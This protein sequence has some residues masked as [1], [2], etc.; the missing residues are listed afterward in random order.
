M[1]KETP[2]AVLIDMDGV[3]ADFDLATLDYMRREIPGFKEK[4][5]REHFYLKHDYPEHEGIINDLHHGEGHFAGLSIIEGA[6]GGLY[7]IKELGHAIR[8]C[9]APISS[10][11]HSEP[12]KRAWLMK[13]L[14]PHFGPDIAT[15]AIIDRN[16]YLYDGIALVDDRPNVYGS[17]V[18]VWSH[19][20]FDQPYNSNVETQLRVLGWADEQLGE[21]LERAE[22]IYVDLGKTGIR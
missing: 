14:A 17:E 11:P 19:L 21:Y 3:L 5:K 22:K 16:K 7:R 2:P 9:T 6:I 15:D 4:E 18:A 13:D 20:L 8:V 1:L 12:E 10:N